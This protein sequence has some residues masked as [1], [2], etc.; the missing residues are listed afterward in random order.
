MCV[1]FIESM[2][3]QGIWKN[4]VGPIRHIFFNVCMCHWI[5]GTA[6]DRKEQGVGPVK[7]LFQCVY[8]SLNLWNCKGSERTG[9]GA[10][11]THHC[12][13]VC[14]VESMELQG[15]G[16][17]R[18]WGQL[19]ASLLMGLFRWKWNWVNQLHFQ[20]SEWTWRGIRQNRRVYDSH[21]YSIIPIQ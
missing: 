21:S 14:F 6:R 10:S 20:G 18:V 9:C 4:G 12:S 1:Y 19:H 15:I 5:N 3:L 13:W 8:V 11:Y 17:N 2:E 7:H 16:K